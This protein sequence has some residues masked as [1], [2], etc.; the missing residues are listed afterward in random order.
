M[1]LGV[2]FSIVRLS[3]QSLPSAWLGLGTET[4]LIENNYHRVSE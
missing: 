3:F 4:A 2:I 1:G